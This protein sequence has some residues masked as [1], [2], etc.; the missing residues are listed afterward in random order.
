MKKLAIFLFAI[1]MA[2]PA[3]AQFALK[4][5][6]SFSKNELSNYVVTAQFYKDLLVVSGDLLIPTHDGQK[7]AGAGRIGLGFGG[8]RLR[9]AGDVGGMYENDHW[10]CGFG[11][12]GNLRLYGPIGLFVRW[13][14]MYPIN[15][16]DD[17]NEVSWDSK[18]SEVVVGVVIEL[19]NGSCY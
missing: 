16:K 11:F 2:M 7:L 17:H 15:K 13:D 10:K 3:G 14:Q 9:V 19:F 4:G 18:R 5:G 1:I 6:V 8:Y 12:E